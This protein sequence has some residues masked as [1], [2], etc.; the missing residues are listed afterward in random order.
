MS[1]I[2]AKTGFHNSNHITLVGKSVLE[3]SQQSHSLMMLNIELSEKRLLRN[4]GTKEAI[5][6]WRFRE[7]RR[8]DWVGGDGGALVSA[9]LAFEDARRGARRRR[10]EDTMGGEGL[11]LDSVSSEKVLEVQA[12]ERAEQVVTMAVEEMEWYVVV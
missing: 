9:K 1:L 10:E 5:A 12:L 4:G 3:S 8:R 2:E 6:A 11:R 7:G